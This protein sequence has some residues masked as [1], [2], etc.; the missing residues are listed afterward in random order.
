MFGSANATVEAVRGEEDLAERGPSIDFKDEY[1]EYLALAAEL[2]ADE[3]LVC[4]ANTEVMAANI[5]QGI[6]S[7]DQ[8]AIV[9]RIR[10]ELPTVDLDLLMDLPRLGDTVAHAARQAV[11][12]SQPTGL[13]AVAKKANRVRHVLFA[14]LDAL[15]AA[16][17]VTREEYEPLRKGKGMVDLANDLIDAAAIFARHRARLEGKLAI[18]PEL[19]A[20]GRELGE[21][22][23]K[24]VVPKSAGRLKAGKKSASAERRDRLWTLLVRRYQELRRVAY[25]IW[26]DEADRYVPP[27]MSCRRKR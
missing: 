14:Q 13:L 22:L 2:P 1:E 26:L 21:Y 24:S 15:V 20:E 18:E 5:R 10:A 19:I 17:L 9:E 12:V 6:R 3:I 25:W 27:L 7:V 4:R 11:P 8:P 16:K 23:R